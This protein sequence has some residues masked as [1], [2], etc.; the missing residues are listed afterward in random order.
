MAD[1]IAALRM[2]HCQETV[3]DIELLFFGK[4]TGRRGHERAVVE[5]GVERFVS[6]CDER[7]QR[8]SVQRML[9]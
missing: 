8:L 9:L 6:N 1:E 3:G 5:F 7:Y 2:L 4:L